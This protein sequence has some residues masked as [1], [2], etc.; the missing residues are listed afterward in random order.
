MAQKSSF[1][2]RLRAQTERYRQASQHILGRAQSDIKRWVQQA[3][4]RRTGKSELAGTSAPGVASARAQIGALQVPPTW[5]KAGERLTVARQS[6][7]H[8][9]KVAL[10]WCW[11]VLNGIQFRLAVFTGGLIAGTIF[12]LSTSY[13][14]QQTEILRESY[15][16]EAAISRNYISSLVLELDNISQSLIR[17]EEFRLRVG[18]QTRALKKYQTV[19]TTVTVT[20]KKKEVS[21]LGI[22]SNWFGMA[23]TEKVE[24]K[25]T[26]TSDN[27]FTTYL[28]NNDTQ[29]LE[30]NVLLL[31]QQS[32]GTISDRAFAA[33]QAQAKKFVLADR[34]LVHLKEQLQDRQQREALLAQQK[35]DAADPARVKAAAETRALE[36]RVRKQSVL[37]RKLRSELDASVIAHLL[38]ARKRKIQELGLDTGRFRIQTFS[39]LGLEPGL[40]PEAA[41]DT[42]LFDPD[43]P[44]NQLDVDAALED[45]LRSAFA[46]IR[47]NGV[48]RNI[49]P[50]ALRMDGLELQALYSPYFEHPASTERARLLEER[51]PS[52]KLR[53]NERGEEVP[54]WGWAAYVAEEQA[55]LAQ[56]ARITPVLRTRLKTLRETNPP[57]PPYRDAAFRAQYDRYAKLVQ[58]RN[59]LYESFLQAHPPSEEERLAVEAL[60]TLRDAALEDQLLVRFRTDGADSMRSAR[61]PEERARS[62][63]RWAALRE[64]IYSG[65]S[66]TPT[67][68]LKTLFSDGLIGNS[69]TEAEEVLWKLDTTPLYSETGRGDL[70]QLVLGENFAGVTRT[71]VDRTDGLR[72]IERNR[73]KAVEMALLIFGGAVLLAVAISYIAV[74]KIK[75]LIRNAEKVGQG[76]LEV[77]FPTRGADE[78]GSLS[79]ALNRMVGGL[80]EREKIKGILGNMIDPVVVGEAMKD[81][82]ALKRGSELRVTAFF[83]D[84]AG[85]SSI[86][87]KL[88]SV[89]LANLLNEYLSAMTLILK[90]HEG[91]LDKYIGD[92]IVGIFNA[93][94]P[95]EE[96]SLKAVRASLKMLHKLEELRQTWKRENRYMPEVHE[97]RI[98]I[99]LNVG[100]AKVGFMGTDALASYTMMGDTVNLAARLEAAGK[101]YGV[102]LLV[103]DAVYQEVKDHVYARKLDLVRVKG[104]REPV[105]LYEPIAEWPEL[106]QAEPDSALHKR[107][108]AA[109]LYGEGLDLYLARKWDEAIAKFKESE[110]V[111]GETDLAVAQLVARCMEYRQNPPPADWDGVYTRNHK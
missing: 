64:W 103:S 49:K 51:R 80:R 95:V 76:D 21:F 24:E 99:G 1:K 92:A 33:L 62:L 7:A 94:V 27:Y 78:F 70:P 14:Q 30:K 111:R 74:R 82:A 101:D 29:V 39:T 13:V 26:K 2:S 5:G 9:T 97:M 16:R 35:P 106:E 53:Y 11:R 45:S 100:L 15:E 67:P 105:V 23:G 86:S 108:A 25:Q 22:K 54:P 50:V 75:R 34:E 85:F 19:T 52:I 71:I 12:I 48:L 68:Q 36:E 38:E 87:E 110:Q 83:S 46:S 20:E 66:E 55:I 43:S 79:R 107:Q 61:S 58:Q 77:A 10:L 109:R 72:A 89:E 91:V 4:A 40:P 18:E 60:G 31:L 57:T 96:H 69:R 28:S 44:L 42:R 65:R 6:V 37:T 81:M 8:Y 3:R 59:T 104:K 47:Q 93:P 41:V 17:V 88:S 98:R 32:G 84:V 90:E 56:L 102:S 73:D 63:R